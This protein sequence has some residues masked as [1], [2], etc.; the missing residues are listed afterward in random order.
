MTVCINCVHLSEKELSGSNMGNLLSTSNQN[1]PLKN[2]FHL[3]YIILFL[4][5]ISIL[6][7]IQF[8][9]LINR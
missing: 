3:L 6:P 2:L 5:T 7:K 8:K 4:F 1:L 9:I